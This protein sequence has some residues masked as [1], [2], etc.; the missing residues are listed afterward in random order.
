MN[1]IFQTTSIKCRDLIDSV[2]YVYLAE[3]PDAFEH[4]NCALGASKRSTKT[5][6]REHIVT[7]KPS[8]SLDERNLIN[9]ET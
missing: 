5:F 4:I 7:S 6:G 2:Q 3:I 1:Y 8:E 9:Y